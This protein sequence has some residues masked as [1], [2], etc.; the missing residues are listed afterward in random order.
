MTPRNDRPILS[1]EKALHKD[2]AAAVKQNIICGLEAQ[3]GLDI[4]TD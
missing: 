4:K 3:M 2:K 1:S